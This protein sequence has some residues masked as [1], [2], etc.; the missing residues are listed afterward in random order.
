MSGR[1][2]R[3]MRLRCRPRIVRCRRQV[4]RFRRFSAVTTCRGESRFGSASA[5]DIAELNPIHNVTKEA[6]HGRST[7][8]PWWTFGYRFLHFACEDFSGPQIRRPDDIQREIA[9][10]RCP[11]TKTAAGHGAP[12]LAGRRSRTGADWNESGGWRSTASAPAPTEALPA[13]TQDA[14]GLPLGTGG[15]TRLRPSRLLRSSR[16]D[17]C[18]QVTSAPAQGAQRVLR[19]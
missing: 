4:I 5:R 1:P 2:S 7:I 16:A 12:G 3:T 8:N 14:G 18:R 13:G 15:G 10:S 19:K 9:R 6:Q 11:A 17:P